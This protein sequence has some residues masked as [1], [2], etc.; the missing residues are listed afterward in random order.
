MLDIDGTVH[1]DGMHR[2]K[3]KIHKYGLER[4]SCLGFLKTK[5]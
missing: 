5:S 4:A 3:G 1:W 2:N